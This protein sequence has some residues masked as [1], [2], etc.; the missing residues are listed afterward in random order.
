M[1]PPFIRHRWQLRCFTEVGQDAF[2]SG[3]VGSH[4]GNMSLRDG[5]RVVI[6]RHGAR[7]GRLSR[8]GLVAFR[9][10][11]GGIPIGAS[12]E[13][14]LHAA[15]YMRT[16]KLAVFHA[17]P[18]HAIALSLRDGAPEVFPATLEAAHYL[19]RVP[20]VDAPAGPAVAASAE[21]LAGL[22]SEFRLI[23]SRGHGTYAAGASLEEALQWTSVF[24]EACK[25]MLAL[26]GRGR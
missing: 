11:S 18:A 20:V 4:S 14:A 6:T 17:H 7:L 2:L 19:P 21:E 23:V 12:S 26:R 15:V 10:D 9:L 8:A 3:L 25:A 1:S 16:S 22:L 24:E 13:A 5:L